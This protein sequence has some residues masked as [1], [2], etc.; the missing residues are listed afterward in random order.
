[1]L[2]AGFS[3]VYAPVLLAAFA[4]ATVVAIALATTF[5]AMISS[6]T[7]VSATIFSRAIKSMA[8]IEPRDPGGQAQPLRDERESN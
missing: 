8:T 6:A 3:L 7:I 2:A 5:L 1:M 4:V